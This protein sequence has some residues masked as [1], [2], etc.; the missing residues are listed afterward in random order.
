MAYILIAYLMWGFFPAFFPL[1]LPAGP[2]EILSHRIL[3]CAIFMVIVMSVMRNWKELRSADGREWRRIVAA[4][5]LISGNW[6]TYVLAVN[7]G[8]VA[9]A[10]LGY[11]INPLLSIALAMIFLG[12]K[13][14]RLQ[15]ISVAIAAVGV[16]WLTV[17]TGQPPV[18]ALGMAFTF[19]FYGLVKKRVSL[20]AAA[21]L[22]AET[23]VV[24]PI[25]AAYL[26]YLEATGAST[27]TTEGAGHAVL[28]MVA[29]VITAAPLFFF[30]AGAKRLPLSTIGMLQ[31]STP[32]MQMIWAV[33]VMDEH[34]STNR[35]IGFL[36]IWIAV[37]VYLWDL[38]AIR[39]RARRRR[40]GEAADAG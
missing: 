33:I 22:T 19:G 4:G 1:L 21:S 11:Y 31:Y 18:M 40:R 15:L 12:E 16:V 29:G 2:L 30:G 10:A 14:R 3:W 24:S 32:T 35:W 26:L 17:L 38:I 39:R 34:L 5:L 7:S 23:L 28:L 20:S 25:A 37:A 9:D 13:L 27:F 8:N 36:I 6:G